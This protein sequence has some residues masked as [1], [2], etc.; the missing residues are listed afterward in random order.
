M[1][2]NRK[3][4]RSTKENPAKTFSKPTKLTRKQ[5]IKQ[6]N[7][8]Q[9]GKKEA[10]N[11]IQRRQQKKTDTKEAKHKEE[12]HWKKSSQQPKLTK[13]IHRRKTRNRQNREKL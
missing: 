2:Y 10:E 11:G 9:E 3:E 12:L 4:V 1:K 7:T 13:K 8:N 5:R 6:E